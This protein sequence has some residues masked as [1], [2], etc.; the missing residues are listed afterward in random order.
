MAA[1]TLVPELPH[2]VAQKIRNSQDDF[3]KCVRDNIRYFNLFCKKL[4]KEYKWKSRNSDAFKAECES[5][6]RGDILALNQLY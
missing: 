6:A 3:V 5:I 2:A 1:I 4:P